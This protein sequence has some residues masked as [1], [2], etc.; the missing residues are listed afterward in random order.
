ME[1]NY[2]MELEQL[3]AGFRLRKVAAGDEDA[4]HAFA[5]GLPPHD[6]LYL[7]R[8]ISKRPVVD[9][10]VRDSVSGNIETLIVEKDGEIIANAA[11]IID[12]K[13]WS[14]HVG[15]IRVLVAKDH[16]KSGIGRLLIEQTFAIAISRELRKIIAQMTIDQRNAIKVFEEM[17]FSGEALLKDHVQDTT[18]EFHDILILSC[19]VNAVTTRMAMSR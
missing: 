7:R 6:L 4:L 2:P 15:E 19:S 3:G 13:S 12:T 11:L 10:W 8:D 17:G 5:L 16:R 18:G 14:R 9:A 1:L